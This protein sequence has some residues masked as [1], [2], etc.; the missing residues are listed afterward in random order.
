MAS[1]PAEAAWPGAESSRWLA[2]FIVGIPLLLAGLILVCFNRVWLNDNDQFLI[3]HE[4]QFWNARLFGLAKQW[5]PVMAGGLN[6]AADPQIPLFSLSMLLAYLFG[7]LYGMHLGELLYFVAGWAGMFCYTRTLGGS[8]RVRALAASL[9]I[10]N[11]FFICRLSYGHVDHIPFLMLPWLLWAAHR[12]LQPGRWRIWLGLSA[13]MALVMDGAPVA[14]IHLFFW[15]GCYTLVLSIARRSGWPLLVLAGAAAFAAVLDAGYLWP[16]VAAQAEFPRLTADTFTNPLCL[17]FFMLIP[18]TGKPLPAPANGHEYSVFIG[19]ILAWLIWRYRRQIREALPAHARWAL[20]VTAVIAV[21][22]GMGSLR[23]LGIPQWASLFDV[24]R[25]LPGFRSMNVTGRYWGFLALPLS[26]MAALALNAFA[27]QAGQC[28]HRV[29]AVVALALLLQLGFA[30]YY[31]FVNLGLSIRYQAVP[32]RDHFSG[33]GADIEYI[34]A[35]EA[36]YQSQLTTPTK[37]VIDAYNM[38]DFIRP[39]MLPGNQLVKAVKVGGRMLREEAGVQARF[40]SWNQI[41][42]RVARDLNREGFKL[43]APVLVDLWQA[44][45]RYWHASRGT[46]SATRWNNLLLETNVS[47]LQPGPITLTFRDP[48]SDLGVKYSLAAWPLWGVLVVLLGWWERRTPF[49]GAPAAG[50]AQG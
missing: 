15:V 50:A 33:G 24:L 18:G 21:V 7:P 37:G 5:S 16:M 42:V 35:G 13:V 34:L 40:L 9:F 48:V 8:L 44:W 20:L 2:G 45:N 23:G 3:F 4:M 26:L 25:P 31:L 27:T 12:V 30:G 47:A 29:N 46:L 39:L 32:Y 43:E 28:R 49:W 36:L 17:L 10:G 41:E 11:G 22:M 14:I 38:G 19:P 1:S 6:M